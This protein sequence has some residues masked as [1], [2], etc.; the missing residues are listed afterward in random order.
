MNEKDR[1]KKKTVENSGDV[2]SILDQ[3]DY[4][5]NL[6][7]RFSA[8]LHTTIT[9]QRDYGNG[10]QIKMLDA[11]ILKDVDEN[12][13]MLS[14]ELAQNWCRTRSAICIIV[15]RLEKSGYITKEFI[16]G[17]KKERA[18][19][20]TEKGHQLC[21][22]HRRYDAMQTSALINEMMGY[23]DAKE[24]DAYFK[25][26]DYQIKVMQKGYF[27]DKDGNSSFDYTG[28]QNGGIKKLTK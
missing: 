7:F 26:L 5:G 17:N 21:E 10:E 1:F 15:Q 24:I 22:L 18:L 19:F 8:L 3:L 6:K 20:V 2:N 25:V 14:V 23:C 28:V 16:D 9:E 27:I 12:P 11:H 13:G 4:K